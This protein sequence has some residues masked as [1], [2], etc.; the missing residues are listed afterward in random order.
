MQEHLKSLKN[1]KILMIVLRKEMFTLSLALFYSMLQMKKLSDVETL[2]VYT[3][4][5]DLFGQIEEAIIRNNKV[6]SWKVRAVR[7]SFLA[8]AM[9]GAKG[10]IVPHH[11]VK[12]IGTIMI[13][14]RAAAPT[15]VEEE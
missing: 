9:P 15:H 12:S 8:K 5:G 10:V 6:E 4:A 2:K 7:D 11:L 14:S 3:D 13:V 1:L